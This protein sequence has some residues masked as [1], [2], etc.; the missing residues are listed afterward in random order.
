MPLYRCSGAYQTRQGIQEGSKRDSFGPF[1][2]ASLLATP[3]HQ[4]GLH[5]V[6]GLPGRFMG[7]CPALLIV[8]NRAI[9][10]LTTI[11]DICSC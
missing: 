2:C 3:K 4:M 7:G 9:A 5:A 10:A 6:S 11:S 1:C 8:S